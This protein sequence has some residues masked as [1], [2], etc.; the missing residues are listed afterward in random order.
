MQPIVSVPSALQYF[1]P[2]ASLPLGLAHPATPAMTEQEA[3]AQVSR[4]Y[5]MQRAAQ[6]DL[7]ACALYSTS[8]QTHTRQSRHSYQQELPH[9]DEYQP[10]PHYNP[11]AN[12]HYSTSM[13]PAR[14][15]GYQ[16]QQQAYLRGLSQPETRHANTTAS[17][18]GLSQPETRHANTTASLRGLSQ[19]ETRHANTTASLRG[20]S[21]PETR[22]ANT[23]ASL[24][25]LSQ[26]E[27]RHANTTASLR[28]L[29]QPE[30][31]HANTT[32]SLR[33]L[34]Q[35]ETHHANTPNR[36]TTIDSNVPTR[37]ISFPRIDNLRTKRT[38]PYSE[39]EVDA[40]RSFSTG[41]HN[42][43]KRHLLRLWE[44]TH[45]ASY[46]FL[47]GPSTSHILR[48]PPV[49]PETNPDGTPKP[50]DIPEAISNQ[51]LEI[52]RLHALNAARTPEPANHR[53]TIANSLLM[54]WAVDDIVHRDCTVHTTFL[55]TAATRVRSADLNS[56]LDLC[57]NATRTYPPLPLPSLHTL[58]FPLAFLKLDTTLP[59]DQR[60]KQAY[61]PYALLTL[62]L[63]TASSLI[64]DSELNHN[65]ITNLDSALHQWHSAYC[66]SPS[67]QD[68]YEFMELVNSALALQE[69]EN[70]AAARRQAH[71]RAETAHPTSQA[72]ASPASAPTQPSGY[73]T[74]TQNTLDEI[75]QNFSIAQGIQVDGAPAFNND[76]LL[77]GDHFSEGG[78]SDEN[79]T[80]SESGLD[81]D[82]E[83][84]AAV[85]QRPTRGLKRR[86]PE[87][88][89]L[90]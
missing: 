35:P 36:G 58:T 51:M 7:D 87:S 3:L 89:D 31:R 17:L 37:S 66:L 40:A 85:S 64:A 63:A 20:L 88:D 6:S 34:S 73:D 5:A 82:A 9:E 29:S 32:A 50:S 14:T 49:P 53:V 70:Q 71:T 38:E 43:I 86:H 13:Y 68:P 41:K 10:E 25:G 18:R 75:L 26:P 1:P 62:P 61:I 78:N 57:N 52:L 65:V 2:P 21:Q 19:P 55:R 54:A 84:S 56:F 39:H 24:R 90:E 22:H 8:F 80:N 76:A 12:M 46:C 79:G 72:P 4:Q 45:T 48:E 81:K 23:T 16:D 33:G 69:A 42:T 83:I 60:Q 15:L 30:T 59:W 28:G 47:V 11:S 67:A 44:L 27:T 77:E 74:H